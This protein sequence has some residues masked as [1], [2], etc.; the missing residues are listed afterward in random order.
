MA[1]DSIRKRILKL[2]KDTDEHK[3]ER[4]RFSKDADNDS[5]R[6][7]EFQIWDFAGQDIYYT[8]HQVYTRM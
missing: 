1:S 6:V 8:T 3:N 4:E 5:G 2:L 7:P